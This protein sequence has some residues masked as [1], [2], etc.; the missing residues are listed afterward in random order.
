MK[1]V[2][3][4]HGGAGRIVE[5]LEGRQEACRKAVFAGWQCLEQGGSALDAVE[6]AVALLED[7]P[8]FNAG[9]GSV[10][11]AA[12]DVEMDA[13][14]MEGQAMR[15]GAVG[16]VRNIRNP[17]RLS[18]RILEDG[19][20]VLLVAE[21]AHRFARDVGMEACTSE[22]L[23]EDRQRQRWQAMRD[24][25]FGT[26]G[27]VALDRG[28]GIA[29]ATSTGGILG[30]RP[31]RVGDSALIGCG[32]YADQLLGAASATGNGEAIIRV[33]L[34]KTAVDLL[35]G[36]CHPLDAARTAIG[37]LER[38][39]QGEGGIIVLD[40]KGRISHAH[41]TPCMAGAFMDGTTAAPVVLR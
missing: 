38:R 27:A 40:R 35:A 37:I 24:T 18:R 12:G 6:H 8:L 36:E 3:I 16:A 31:G 30:K 19:R 33:V 41:N 4:V 9:R 7:H 14:L 20:H 39:T 13:S 11:N 17:V 2:I 28:G 15:A 25:A 29:A 34:A 10:L 23:V 22:E 5:E 21:G 32:T 26:V 1:Q